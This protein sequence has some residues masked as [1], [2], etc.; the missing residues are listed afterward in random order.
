V[1]LSSPGGDLAQAIIMGEIIRSRGP[2]LLRQLCAPKTSSEY[3]AVMESPKL[4][5]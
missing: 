1:L 5:G 2:R 3:D 4:A